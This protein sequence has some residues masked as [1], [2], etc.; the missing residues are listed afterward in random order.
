MSVMSFLTSHCLNLAADPKR[1][2]TI[3]SSRGMA[4]NLAYGSSGA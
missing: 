4:A 2:A 3:L 1:R